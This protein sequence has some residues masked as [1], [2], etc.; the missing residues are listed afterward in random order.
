VQELTHFLLHI[1]HQQKIGAVVESAERY[2]SGAALMSDEAI[3][4]Q[5][6]L[7]KFRLM[8][9]REDGKNW[10]LLLQNRLIEAESAEEA[11]KAALHFLGASAPFVCVKDGAAW[12]IQASGKFIDI[13]E[14]E[15]E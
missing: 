11:L 7:K 10:P 4:L 15:L 13:W 12:A 2:Q 5:P 6:T 3:T 8:H 14:S 9:K 1:F